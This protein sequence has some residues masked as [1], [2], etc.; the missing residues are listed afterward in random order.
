[1]TTQSIPPKIKSAPSLGF[2]AVAILATAIL[3][4]AAVV[5]FF[6]PSRYGFYPTCLFH[7]VTG[8]NCPGCG[9]TR[10]FYALLHGHFQLAL[11]DNALFIF[12]LGATAIRGAWFVQ[13]KI[14]RKPTGEFFPTKWLWPLLIVAA[15]FTILRN[16]PAF[17]FLSP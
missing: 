3:G 9:A 14:F 2:F 5:F 13:R 10:S 16:L 4:V 17:S 6:N 7:Q 1:M 15:M 8:L 12:L 11:K